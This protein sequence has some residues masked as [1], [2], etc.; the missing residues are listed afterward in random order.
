MKSGG[1]AC[2]CRAIRRHQRAHAESNIEHAKFAVTSVHL[3]RRGGVT[4]ARRRAP[5]YELATAVSTAASR[6]VAGASVATVAG[7]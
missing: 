4:L 7:P 5:W 1:V 2:V 6:A 3:G